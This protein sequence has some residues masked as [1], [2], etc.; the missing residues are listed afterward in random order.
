MAFETKSTHGY[1]RL[2]VRGLAVIVFAVFAIV[3]V[4][5][6]VG[7]SRLSADTERRLLAERTAEIGG[8]LSSSVGTGLQS[9]LTS[10]A[11][12]AQQS[13]QTDFTRIAQNQLTSGS[14]AGIALVAHRGPSWVVQT[15]VGKALVPGQTLTGSRLS[16]VESAGGKIRSDVFVVSAGQSRLGVVLGPP[17]AP[18]GTVVYQEF[19]VD[20]ARPA[21]VTQSQPFHELNVALYVGTRPVAAKL[22]LSTT[23]DVPLRGRVA[24]GPVTAGD[25][26]WLVVA[27]ARQ[28]L[29]GTLA[30]SVP[31]IL[32][33]AVLLI[34][35]AMT[36]VVESVSR[37]RDYALTLVAQRTASL[38]ESLGQLE[39]TQQALVANERLAALGQMAA[40]V[41]HELRN[42][43]GV[44]TNSLYLIRSTVSANA[45]DTL[46]RQ[47]DT[48][49]R[50]ISAATLIVS[51]LLEFARPRTANPTNFDVADLLAEAISVAP[52][53]SG[54]S[55]E[56]DD[57]QVPPIAAD[58]DQ[59][60][61]V[62]LNL[63]TNAYEAMP[64]GGRIRIGARVLD[65]AVEVAVSDTGVGMDEQTRG[66]VFEPFFSLKVKGTGLGLAVSKRIVE[67]HCGTLTMTSQ[68]GQGC[69][70]VMRLPLTPAGVGAGR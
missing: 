52:P 45:D 37:R 29:A 3:A 68:Q 30:S 11:T 14:V 38:Q 46:R 42:P 62:V 12:A 13:R 50:E 40:T 57:D 56:Q 6:F 23:R 61:Q 54:I 63:L 48:A 8:L 24:S 10:L 32:L 4:G 20:P 41:G 31:K 7:A 58:R 51:D 9:S 1:R 67:A 25:S 59:I 60:R 53:P 19:A 21:Q 43:L 70:A 39:Q 35:I 15:S 55:I 65:D 66:Q 17:V 5:F 69:T 26:T 27:S 2:Q 22:I 47:L 18:S 64:S 33:L 28:P 49:D 44:L 16:L 34:G 36:A